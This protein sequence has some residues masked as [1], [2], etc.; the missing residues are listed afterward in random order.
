MDI[1]KNIAKTNLAYR[2][3]MIKLAF[4]AEELG[5]VETRMVRMFVLKQLVKSKEN[6]NRYLESIGKE[7]VL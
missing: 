7:R 1:R 5:I 6:V 3:A 2:G 4:V